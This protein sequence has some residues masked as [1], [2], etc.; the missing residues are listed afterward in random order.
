MDSAPMASGPQAERTGS[1]SAAQAVLL[2]MRVTMEAG[3]IAGFSYWGVMQGDSVGTKIAF[4][5]LAPVV[6]FG[7][8][9]A[10]DFRFAGSSAEVLRLIEEL[11]ISLL[12][13]T[14]LY[15]TGR[16]ALGLA[17]GSLSIAYHVMV[18]MSGERL[19]DTRAAPHAHGTAG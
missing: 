12:A 7:V 4:G 18:Y 17:L 8:W 14:A 6:G 3:I 10:L 15:S 11:A 13:A 1:L 2:V 16:E 5:V 9:G 19:L